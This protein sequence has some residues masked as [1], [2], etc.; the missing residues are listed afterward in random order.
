[1]HAHFAAHSIPLGQLLAPPFLV[2]TPAYQRSYA[3]T[4]TEA[5]RLLDDLIAGAET[6]NSSGADAAREDYFLGAILLVD[7]KAETGTLPGWPFSGGL[8]S[9]EVVDGLQRLTTLA[10]LFCVLRSI[11]RDNGEPV[12]LAVEAAIAAGPEGPFW[13]SLRGSDEAFFDR[14]V[15][16]SSNRLVQNGDD[17]HPGEERILAVRD[18]LYTRLATLDAAHRTRLARFVLA[19]CYVVL[20]ATTGIDRAHRMFMVLNERGKPLARHDILKADC[21]GRAGPAATADLARLWDDMEA[22]LGHDFE[23]LFGYVR[24]MHGRPNGPIISSI[25]AIADQAGGAQ[26]FVADILKP[27]ADAL[28]D[29]RHARA[30]KWPESTEIAQIL[31]YLHWLPAT[32][33]LPP[34]LQF[35]ISG[36]GSGL[37]PIAYFKALDKLAYG[38][39]IMGLGAGKR[40]TRFAA[41]TAALRHGENVLAPGGPLSLTGQEERTVRYNLRD[42]HARAPVAAKLLLLR[43]NDCVAGSPQNLDPETLTVEHVLPRKHNVGSQWRQWFQDPQERSA[44]TESLGNLLLV[45]RAQ[46]DKAGNLELERKQAI[47]FQSGIPVPHINQDLHGLRAWQPQNVLAREA[48]F[49]RH[50]DRLWNFG[51]AKARAEAEPETPPWPEQPRRARA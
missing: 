38:F 19:N 43:L 25:R 23:A 10:M 6:D 13:L 33:W 14:C 41:V 31:R 49:F 21:L 18:M 40:A 4:D 9:F 46:N 15:R 45:T 36:A 3:W 1:M 35:W 42:L 50:L 17:A 20:I 30:S 5:G 32:D 12:D 11:A 44:C 8:R 27:A 22:R 37:S 7:R 28:D 47:Y 34:A 29:I 48:E 16:G 2:E 39:K 24:A 51:L 26:R